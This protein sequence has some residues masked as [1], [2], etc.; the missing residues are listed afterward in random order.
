MFGSMKSYLIE[1][2]RFVLMS[3]LTWNVMEYTIYG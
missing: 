2:I 1:T 3:S